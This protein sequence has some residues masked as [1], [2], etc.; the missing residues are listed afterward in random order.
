VLGGLVGIGAFSAFTATTA[1]TGNTIS[2]GTVNIGQH[3]G[4]TTLYSVSNQ[5]PGATTVACVRVTYSG[6]I[7]ASAVKLY[8]SSVTNGTVYNLKVERGAGITSPGADMNCTGF[9][10]TSTA[11]DGNLGSFGTTYGAGVDGK[12]S[13]ATWATSSA[14]DYKF[15]ITVNDDATANAHTSSTSS[16]SHDFTW[17]ARS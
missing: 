5:S 14:V 7:T 4:S 9:S 13:A 1:N 2:S 11:Y 17:E 8:T 6:T 15:T 10:A 16:G 12:A 3:A